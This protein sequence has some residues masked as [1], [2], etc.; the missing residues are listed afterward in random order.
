MLLFINYHIFHLTMR[1][2]CVNMLLTEQVRAK[3]RSQRVARGE[4]AAREVALVPPVHA[5]W[6][7][8]EI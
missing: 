5:V 7:D 8:N 1:A 4:S 3:G 2:V 6:C